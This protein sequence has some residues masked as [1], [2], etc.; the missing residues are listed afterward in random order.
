MPDSS[1]RPSVILDKR[2]ANIL[3][4]VVAISFFM[5]MLDG[6]ILNTALPAIAAGLNESPLNMHLVVISYLLTAAILIPTSGWLA[7]RIGIRRVFLTAIC[8]FTFGSLLCSMSS[9]LWMLVASRVIQGVGGALMVPVGRLIILRAYPRTHLV[10]LLG[11]VTIPGMLGPLLGP[12]LG[13]WLVEYASWHWIFLINI[14]VGIIGVIVARKFV[15]SFPVSKKMKFDF[16][17]FLV[18]SASMVLI[19]LGL[20]DF[21]NAE[22]RIEVILFL[23]VGLLLLAAYWLYASRVPHALFSL[24]LF[25]TRTFA[26]GIIGNLFARFGMGA[27]PYLTPL[28][29]QVGMGFS[30]LKAGMSMIP[31]GISAIVGKSFA[32]PLIGRFGYRQFL[33]MNTM[34]LGAMMFSFSFILSYAPYWALLIYFGIFGGINALQYTAMNTLT[35]IDLPTDQTASG[36]SLLSVVM[37]LS[38]SI[39]TAMGAALL[40]GFSGKGDTG[41]ALIPAFRH[42]YMVVGILTFI[43][44]TIFLQLIKGAQRGKKPNLVSRIGSGD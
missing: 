2:T 36:N 6:T 40:V 44:S 34:L 37:Q 9:A 10:E 19:S 12:T 30:A 27:I 26:I 3:P 41:S 32:K 1:F 35:L 28:L 20:E 8:I 14:P 43:S 24:K 42:T 11:F 7:D 15:P 23:T 21:G 31:L 29:L 33:V 22:S 4:W 13:G 5:Q 17:G 16:P 25:K 39:G 18:M 38:L